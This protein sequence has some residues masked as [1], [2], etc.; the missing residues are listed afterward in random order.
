MGGG[1]MLTDIPP[2]FLDV[3]HNDASVAGDCLVT[4]GHASRDGQTQAVSPNSS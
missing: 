3:D 2:E 1:G 4:S